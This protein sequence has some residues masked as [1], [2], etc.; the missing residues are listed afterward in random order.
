MVHR[1]HA[2]LQSGQE[3]RAPWRW[4]GG[5]EEEGS[6]R[7]GALA[8]TQN[9]LERQEGKGLMGGEK[10]GSGELCEGKE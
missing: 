7:D 4:S 2:H 1:H 5:K 6:G 8:K 10:Q 9:P 3:P